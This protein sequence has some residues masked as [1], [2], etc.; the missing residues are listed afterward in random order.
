MK[1]DIIAQRQLRTFRNAHHF[2][3][4]GRKWMRG[5]TAREAYQRCTRPAWL[6]FALYELNPLYQ[7][8]CRALRTARIRVPWLSDEYADRKACAVIRKAVPYEIAAAEVVSAMTRRPWRYRGA[9]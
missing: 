4:D 9:A 7:D 8:A 5:K 1:R 3:R 6:L 2:C